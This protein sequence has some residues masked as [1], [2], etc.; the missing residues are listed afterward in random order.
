MLFYLPLTLRPSLSPCSRMIYETN[1]KNGSSSGKEDLV[2][3]QEVLEEVCEKLG[4]SNKKESPWSMSNQ[5]RSPSSRSRHNEKKGL[6]SYTV[7]LKKENKTFSKKKKKNSIIET[8]DKREK[9]ICRKVV[10]TMF[11]RYNLYPL[12]NFIHHTKEKQ[13]NTHRVIFIILV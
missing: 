6:R 7:S 9:R 10:E 5:R 13:V 1:D 2:V 4:Q 3:H 8:Q 11:K 12:N